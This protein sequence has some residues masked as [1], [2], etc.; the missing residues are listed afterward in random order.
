MKTSLKEIHEANLG[1]PFYLEDLTPTAVR[2]VNANEMPRLE[3]SYIAS[4]TIN[5]INITDFGKY[6]E[7]KSEGGSFYSEGKRILRA[8][9]SETATYIS[10]TVRHSR[11]EGK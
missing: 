9:N 1:E 5:R 10:H 4:A 3:V 11:E 2:V 8:D 7:R 6:Q